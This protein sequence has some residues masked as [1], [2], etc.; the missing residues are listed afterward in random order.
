[1]E[2]PNCNTEIVKVK[3]KPGPKKGSKHTPKPKRTLTPI[4]RVKKPKT[5]VTFQVALELFI[6]ETMTD[7]PRVLKLREIVKSSYLVSH[8]LFLNGFVTDPRSTQL[9]PT[10]IAS[11]F[12]S[13]FGSKCTEYNVRWYYAKLKL[14]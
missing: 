2:C 4:D 13:V 11:L 5:Y 8:S 12:R 6:R 1:M 14:T 10:A 7:K 3:L 9:T